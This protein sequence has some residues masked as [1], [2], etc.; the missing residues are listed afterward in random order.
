MN[1]NNN[2]KYKNV[3]RKDINSII[4]KTTRNETKKK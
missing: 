4:I 2:K 1:E 3:S